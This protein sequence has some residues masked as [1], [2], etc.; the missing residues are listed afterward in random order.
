MKIIVAGAK[1]FLG[2]HILEHYYSKPGFIVT[3]LTRSDCDLT[4]VDALKH[5]LLQEEPDVLIH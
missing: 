2:K 3:G 1:G 4:D 5:Y